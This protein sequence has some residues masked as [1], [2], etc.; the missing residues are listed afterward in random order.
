[1]KRL[2]FETTPTEYFFDSSVRN[3]SILEWVSYNIIMGN[4]L[5]GLNEEHSCNAELITDSIIE[6]S[7]DEDSK[8]IWICLVETIQI[9]ER[10]P[11]G[12]QA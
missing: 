9:N 2:M 1:M 10:N 7:G 11:E 8:Q 5:F 6:I 4:K 3:E 12:F